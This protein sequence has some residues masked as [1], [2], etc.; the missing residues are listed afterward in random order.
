MKMTIYNH[1]IVYLFRLFIFLFIIVNLQSCVALLELGEIGE[2][3]AAGVEVSELGTL[4]L[5]NPE[6]V[7]E[8]ISQVKLLS[9][10]E[11]SIIKNNRLTKFAELTDNNSILLENGKIVKLPGTLYTVNQ[12]VFVRTA[13]F[14]NSSF[15][16]ERYTSGRLV[17]VSDEI[18]G[19]L[20]IILPEHHFGF[21]PSESLTIAH[22]N[23]AHEIKKAI[24]RI[25]G[26]RDRV[27]Y[28]ANADF[29]NSLEAK[30]LI[31]N[32]NYEDG[33]FDEPTSI[34]LNTLAT[35]N[36][37]RST[38]AFFSIN[39]YKDQLSRQLIVGNLTL[40]RKLNLNRYSD[41]LLIGKHTTKIRPN[42]IQRNM[43][44]ADLSYVV[45][46]IN[47][48]NGAIEKSWVN[49]IHGNGWTDDQA[50]NDVLESFVQIIKQDKF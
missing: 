22:T 47:L 39:Y 27:N 14:E 50:R 28:F 46:L 24:P 16:S 4:T 18:N 7:A 6:L 5:V 37:Y 20:E 1:I 41:Y 30:E 44:T 32:I 33:S 29:T 48:K 31:V 12:D 3:G 43:L 2:L 23:R 40:M 13:P 34:M 21:I 9:D 45:N 19:W 49:T 36:G 11:L 42:Q 38:P 25:P 35:Q 26:F 8:E 10:G 15:I 17:I